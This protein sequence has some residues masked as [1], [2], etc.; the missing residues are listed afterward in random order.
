MQKLTNEKARELLKELQYAKA[1]QGQLSIRD[2]YFKQAL[3]KQPRW[4]PCSEQ[5]PPKTKPGS[6]Q[7]YLVYETLNNRVQH[8]CYNV[9][10]TMAPFWNHYGK[11]VTH[12]MP[13]P[14][15]PL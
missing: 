9:P 11:N 15:A 7:E 8:D 4:I 3:E 2:E 10:E 1:Q 14:E 13:L 5:M 6:S 12:W